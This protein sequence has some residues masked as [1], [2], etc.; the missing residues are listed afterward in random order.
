MKKVMIAILPLLLA[1]QMPFQTLNFVPSELLKNVKYGMKWTEL[2]LNGYPGGEDTMEKVPEGTV[3][4][5][6]LI[7][8]A[9]PQ[10]EDLEIAIDPELCTTITIEE[11]AI[12]R[13]EALRVLVEIEVENLAVIPPLQVL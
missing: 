8:G 12:T 13:K 1:M 9:I 7:A 2:M 5:T 4:T 6:V 11:L 10:Q 3:T